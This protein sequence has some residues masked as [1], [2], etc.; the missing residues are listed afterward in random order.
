MNARA[1][2]LSKSDPMRNPAHNET[3]LPPR[4]RYDHR[5][6]SHRPIR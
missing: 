1:D 2:K 6:R 3:C 4:S 5:R